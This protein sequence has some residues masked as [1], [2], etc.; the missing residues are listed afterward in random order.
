MHFVK[1]FI[2]P[3]LLSHSAFAAGSFLNCGD[4]KYTMAVSM[5]VE[6]CTV[7]YGEF[8]NWSNDWGNPIANFEE[9]STIASKCSVKP[10][11]SGHK[12]FFSQAPFDAQI[13]CGT[14]CTGSIKYRNS[15]GK[16]LKRNVKCT[17]G[18]VMENFGI[19]Q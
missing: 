15:S 3:I 8:S 10:T 14:K 13:E 2:L 17:F 9:K 5:S 12:Y 18:N 16:T 7:H 1:F 6:R 11:R 19:A 4:A